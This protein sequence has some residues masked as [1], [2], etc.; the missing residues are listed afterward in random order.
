MNRTLSLIF[1]YLFI[2]VCI[3]VQ[4]DAE[5]LPLDVHS[6][7]WLQCQGSCKIVSSLLH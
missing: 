4:R 2:A 7:F 6:V 5:L 3:S 1:V